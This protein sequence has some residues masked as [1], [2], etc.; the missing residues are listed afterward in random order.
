MGL[1]VL[2]G[3]L[4]VDMTMSLFALTF[5]AE[6]PRLPEGDRAHSALRMTML[7]TFNHSITSTHIKLYG[8]MIRIGNA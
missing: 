7:I 5:S 6:Q 2:E 1:T 8:Y 4:G 3:A